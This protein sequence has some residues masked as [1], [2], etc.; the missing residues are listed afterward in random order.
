MYWLKLDIAY[1]VVRKNIHQALK[2]LQFTVLHLVLWG[3]QKKPDLLTNL[4]HAQLNHAFSST[5]GF[6]DFISDFY[7]SGFPFLL[8]GYAGKPNKKVHSDT[9][10]LR[11][12]CLFHENEG[13]SLSTLKEISYYIN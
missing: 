7:Q 6:K 10:A 4:V 11:K 9:W 13:D 2:C 12:D 3:F 1:T 8:I 5:V